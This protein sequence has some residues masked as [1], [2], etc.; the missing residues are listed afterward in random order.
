[1]CVLDSNGLSAPLLSDDSSSPNF[2]LHIEEILCEDS[3]GRLCQLCTIVHRIRFLVSLDLP[4]WIP[5]VVVLGINASPLISN[6][7]GGRIRTYDLW[8]MSPFESNAVT[9]FNCYNLQQIKGL[10]FSAKPVHV[11]QVHHVNRFLSSKLWSNKAYWISFICSCFPRSLSENSLESSGFLTRLRCL[12]SYFHSWYY[13]V[14]WLEEY[15]H[16]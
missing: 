13:F 4:F 7:S 9:H 15:W 11:A 16:Q 12:C 6:G 3:D 14:Q 2:L 8:V 1:M 5:P 10:C